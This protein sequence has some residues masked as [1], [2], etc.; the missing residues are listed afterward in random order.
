MDICMG[1]REETAKETM[2]HPVDN[3]E[4]A[5]VSL[6]IHGNAQNCPWRLL[7][8]LQFPCLA[9][10]IWEESVWI[11]RQRWS[12]LCAKAQR[13]DNWMERYTLLFLESLD[14]FPN[15]CKPTH[16]GS[17]MWHV[18]VIMAWPASTSKLA[19]QTLANTWGA[20]LLIR[21]CKGATLGFMSV[22]RGDGHFPSNQVQKL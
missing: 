5:Q 9:V 12:L 15:T 8:S 1:T 16:M 19:T 21:K 2:V 10:G 4:S 11:H 17:H 7:V 20:D 3:I 18:R 22:A 13:I 6:I 14:S